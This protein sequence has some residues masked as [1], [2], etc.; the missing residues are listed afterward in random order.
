MTLH[1]GTGLAATRTGGQ[2]FDTA[3]VLGGLV[4]L[5]G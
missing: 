1:H 4:Q 5:P 2:V 3:V